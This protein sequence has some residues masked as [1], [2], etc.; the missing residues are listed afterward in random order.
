MYK[1]GLV[2]EGAKTPVKKAFENVV[3]KGEYAGNSITFSSHA[4]M[5]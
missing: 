4:Q 5:K 2:W 1:Q 3:G